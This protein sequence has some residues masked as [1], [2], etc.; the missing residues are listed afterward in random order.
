M[1]LLLKISD[2]FL[3]WLVGVAFDHELDVRETEA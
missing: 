1:W 2:L 3:D